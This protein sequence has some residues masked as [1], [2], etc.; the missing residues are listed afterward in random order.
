M[1]LCELIEQLQEFDPDLEVFT[2]GPACGLTRSVDIE[3]CLVSLW[4]NKRYSH[5]GVGG[6]I[7]PHERV[8]K[9]RGS[10]RSYHRPVEGL[11]ITFHPTENYY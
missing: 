10:S 11:I 5:E 1:K 6:Y 3:Q 8:D 2:P 4:E 9:I 7:A